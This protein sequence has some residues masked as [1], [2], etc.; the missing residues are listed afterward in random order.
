VTN[1]LAYWDTE[2]ITTVKSFIVQVSGAPGHGS[3]RLK[4]VEQIQSGK[5]PP[6]F[7]DF[8]FETWPFGCSNLATGQFYK[9]LWL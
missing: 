9:K 8:K 3:F 7:G 6:P 4:N 5:Q 2:L 1:T